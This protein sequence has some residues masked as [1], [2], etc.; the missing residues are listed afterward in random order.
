MGSAVTISL[1]H[2][3]RGRV[4][5]AKVRDALK[6]LGDNASLRQIQAH[7]GGGSFRDLVEVRRA[8]LGQAADPVRDAQIAGEPVAPALAQSLAAIELHTA[9]AL[10]DQDQEMA[11]L[12]ADLRR[13]QEAT[14]RAL[15]ALRDDMRQL[16]AEA[17]QALPGAPASSTAA[18]RLETTLLQLQR[19]AFSLGEKAAAIDLAPVLARLDAIEAQIRLNAIQAPLP[20]P[21]PIAVPTVTLDDLAAFEQRLLAALARP[22]AAAAAPAVPEALTSA[23]D[24]LAQGQAAHQEALVAL[25]T[26]TVDGHANAEARL[27]AMHRDLVERHA[28]HARRLSESDAAHQRELAHVHQHLA[29]V[30]SEVRR[31]TDGLVRSQRNQHATLRHTLRSLALTHLHAAATTGDAISRALSSQRRRAAD[32][33]K[34]RKPVAPATRSRKTT[35]ALPRRP[36]TRRTPPRA[37]PSRTERAAPRRSPTKTQRARPKPAPRASKRTNITS[38]KVRR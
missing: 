1:Q 37:K 35:S 2:H 38:R 16:I 7:V 29:A 10:V 12:R 18:L 8:V 9:K 6:A 27:G 34:P 15:F 4:T 13:R 36:A 33:A 26:V 30:S 20:T 21:D 25:R 32:V 19:H 17:R 5:P 22:A 31:A 28:H 3:R 14:Q 11:A 23:L 24:G